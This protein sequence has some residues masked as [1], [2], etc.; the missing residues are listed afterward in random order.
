MWLILLSSLR[1]LSFIYLRMDVS[2]T[3]Q[4]LTFLE[5]HFKPSEKALKILARSYRGLSFNKRFLVD[6]L[7]LRYISSQIAVMKSV[8]FPNLPENLYSRSQKKC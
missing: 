6:I 4:S 5:S 3:W 2:Q 1:I 8:K 7:R